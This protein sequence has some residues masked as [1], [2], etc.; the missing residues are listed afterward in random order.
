MKNLQTANKVALSLGVLLSGQSLLGNHVWLTR[1]F[2]RITSLNTTCLGQL[3]CN[4]HLIQCD[5]Y[6]DTQRT[7][8]Q[9]PR[10]H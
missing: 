10:G 5:V 6:M 3:V 8:V 2:G 9:G 7:L 4:L 1:V